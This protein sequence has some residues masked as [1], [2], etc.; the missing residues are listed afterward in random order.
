[1]LRAFLCLSCL[2]LLPSQ[3]LAIPKSEQELA[4]IADKLVQTSVKYGSIPS[5]YRPQYISVIDAALSLGKDEPVFV[6]RLPDGYRIFPQRIMVWHQVI[7]ELIDDNAY[8]ITYCPISGCRAAY[9]AS[10]D[11]INLIL[12]VEGRL[13]EGNSILMDRNSGSLWV[14]MLGIAF[15]GPLRG[16]GMPMLPAFWTNWNFASRYFSNAQVLAPPLE[17]KKAY[18]RDPYGNY[19]RRDSYYQND[20]LIYPVS[21][22]DRRFHRKTPMLGLEYNNLR[23]GIDIPYVKKNGVVN[24]FMGDRALVAVHDTRMD[25]VRVFDRQIWEKPALFVKES[26]RLKDLGTRSHWSD[27]GK[28]LEGN[29]Q[30]ASMKEMF[31]IYAMWF[32]WFAMNPETLILPGPGEVD[33]ALLVDAPPGS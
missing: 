15:D 7:N 10:M 1:M 3:L 8:V 30:G 11:G 32:A 24:F 4:H 28:C 22:L 23:V 26:G 12:D 20:I 18:G 14:Q 13:F 17:S 27:D 16:R 25:V 33:K 6:V 2:L 31:G 19:Q 9:N 29:L 21:R 5:L